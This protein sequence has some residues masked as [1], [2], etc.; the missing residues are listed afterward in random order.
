MFKN[1]SG[2]TGVTS[3]PSALPPA[4][5]DECRVR[6]VTGEFNA[7]YYPELSGPDAQPPPWVEVAPGMEL[8]IMGWMRY[9]LGL[10]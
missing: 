10:E 5:F 3:P 6:Y 4:L 2:V 9:A 7:R 8:Y 1:H